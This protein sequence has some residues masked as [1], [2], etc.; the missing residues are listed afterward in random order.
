MAINHL[1]C[2]G[3]SFIS[4]I[5]SLFNTEAFSNYA[6]DEVQRPNAKIGLR[7]VDRRPWYKN[8]NFKYIKTYDGGLALY[9]KVMFLKGNY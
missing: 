9:E 8:G 7:I 5:N 4:V 1:D 3:G 6:N 2:D